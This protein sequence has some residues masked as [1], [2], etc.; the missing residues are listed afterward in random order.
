[1]EAFDLER[2]NW[3]PFSVFLK[4]AQ[5]KSK[6]LMTKIC[7]STTPELKQRLEGISQGAKIAKSKIFLLNIL[8]PL[9]S[10]ADNNTVIPG[11]GGCSAVALG[12]SKAGEPTI[13]K[14]FDYLPLIQPFYIV[15]ESRP[16]GKHKSLDFTVAPMAGSVDGIN[17]KGLCITFNYGYVSESPIVAPP[18]SYVISQ[19]LENCS[20]VSEALDFIQSSSRWGA[21]LL[22]LADEKGALASLEL[23]STKSAYRHSTDF[24]FHTNHYFTED[25]RE[26]EV[27]RDAVF[28]DNSPQALKGKCVLESPLKRATRLGQLLQEHDKFS[29]DIMSKIMAD[30]ESNDKPSENTICTHSDYWHTTATMRYFPKTRR[31]QFSFSSACESK[32]TEISL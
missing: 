10:R 25:L 17:E 7:E 13:L 28:S 24:L 23:S 2:P 1:L 14:N 3:L 6:I 22:M 5:I 18:I 32:F 8:E 27:S 19:A 9:M 16:N 21:G 31:A 12:V 11:M 15:R 29:L 4:L 30:H 26:V 20:T